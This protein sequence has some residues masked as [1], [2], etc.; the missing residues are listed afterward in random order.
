M[1]PTEPFRREHEEL[2]SHIEHI[3]QAARE[4]ARLERA[5]REALVGRIVD[6]LRGTLVPH[7]KAEEEVLYPE[8]ATLVGF[9]AAAVPMV[10]DHEAIVARI[11]RLE[12]ADIA[13]A[14]PLATSR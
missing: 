13:R 12:R 3:A 7:A 1:R 5:E 4:V 10:H 14:R 8:W 2:H 9:G 6:F 11:E